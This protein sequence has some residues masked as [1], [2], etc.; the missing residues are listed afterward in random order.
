MRAAMRPVLEGLRVIDLSF[1]IAGP[2][3]AMYLADQGAD[4]IRIDSP[5]PRGY[6]NDPSTDPSG[7]IVQDRNKRSIALDLGQ[8]EGYSVFRK[9]AERSDVLI[10]NMRLAA[11]KKLGVDYETVRRLNPRLIYGH[12]S[13][14]GPKGPYAE[15]GGY[16][17][18]T[19]GLSGAMYRRWE[20]GTPVSTGVFLS[21]PS[22]PMLMG[23][24]IMLALWQREKTGE[25][26][27]VETSLL[28]AA[29]A[30]QLTNL[31]KLESSDRPLGDYNF[32]SY[33]IYRCEDGA[34][35]NV[36]ALQHHQFERLIRLMELDHLLED[37]RMS[38][39]EKRPEFRREIHPIIDAMFATKPSAEWL[40]QLNEA[41]VPAAPILGRDQVFSEPQMV[42]NRMFVEV[43]HPKAGKVQT[44]APPF[45]LSQAE[46]VDHQPPPQPGQHT[47]EVLEGLGYGP[48][49]IADL[50]AKNVVR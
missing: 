23:Y 11:A 46:E 1:G 15:R 3:T 43:D 31:V 45:R 12:I 2:A 36:T 14:F 4:V 10:A 41:D 25:G 30:M 29:I 48:A 49:E 39:P 47:R 27:L 8:P 9:L 20:D 7:F 33:G 38:D 26:Q 16:D 13:A 19:Q 50:Q 44:I 6:S 5:T 35:I 24:G 37:P 21:D 42:A 17:R 22:I 40:A 34:Y 28:Q 32:P 18:L